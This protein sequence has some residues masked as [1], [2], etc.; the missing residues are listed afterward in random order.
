MLKKQ[1]G[2]LYIVAVIL[3]A[4]ISLILSSAVYQIIINAN[5]VRNSLNSSQAYYMAQ[6]GINYA[7]HQF[8]V[9]AASCGQ[10]FTA[11]GFP[12]SPGVFTV[13]SSLSGQTCTLTSTGYIP[14]AT[15]PVAKRILQATLVSYGIAA[16]PLMTANTLVM[17][18]F[19]RITN[20]NV[21]STSPDYPGSTI[22]AHSTITISG[23]AN[24][25]VSGLDPSSTSTLR[26]ADIQ[27]NDA[28]LTSTNLFSSF[29]TKTPAQITSAAIQISSEAQIQNA[30]GGTYYSSG[31]LSLTN[32]TNNS[33]IGTSANPVILIV[34]GNMSITQNHNIYGLIYVINGTL[35]IANNTF[36]YGA[37]AV[38]NSITLSNNS[39]ITLDQTITNNLHNT[40]NNTVLHYNDPFSGLQEIIP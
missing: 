22:H 6:S 36:V 13:T 17:Q 33:S 23:N 27:Q 26:R 25:A 35:T 40:N 32:A 7:Q 2:F 31:P 3:I 4:V 37:I 18:N 9:N 5:E 16:A 14:N 21:T 19:S 30:P 24:T 34:N 1:Q 11:V 29:F 15:S 20:F 8:Y 10:T 38:E 39:T 12:G 28:N